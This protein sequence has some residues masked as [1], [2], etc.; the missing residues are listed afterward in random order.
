MNAY[1]AEFL[2]TAILKLFGGG[3][4]ANVILKGCA[5]NN[6]EWIVIATG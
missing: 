4:C 6:A 1:L 3:V 2:G 5:G